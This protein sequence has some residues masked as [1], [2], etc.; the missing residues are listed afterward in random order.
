MTLKLVVTT[1]VDGDVFELILTKSKYR[2]GRRHDNDLRIKETY[3]SAYHSELNRT[4]EGHYELS[5]CGSSNGTY[6]NG[7]K[8]QKPEK[9]KAGDFIKFGILKVAVKEHED[10]GPT[11]VSLK[12]RPVF[13]KKRGENTSSI[14]PSGNTG[15]IGSI[16][17]GATGPSPVQTG[18]T[19]TTSSEIEE[20]EALLASETSRNESL[21]A[22]LAKQE[23]QIQKLQDEV[24][25][26]E[27]TASETLKGASSQKAELEEARKEQD[28]E[29]E[30]LRA[31]LETTAK[32]LQ[33]KL[34][35]EKTRASEIESELEPE[36]GSAK[37]L[38]KKIAVLEAAQ[39]QEQKSAGAAQ[40]QLE[41]ALTTRT[42][43]LTE[44][45]DRVAEL[46][47]ALL[48][49]EEN[50]ANATSE[51]EAQ[52][53]KLAEK[54]KTLEQTIEELTEANSEEAKAREALEETNR[55]QLEEREE[56]V[57][58]LDDLQSELE[59]EKK[60][61]SSVVEELTK[62]TAVAG[63]VALLKSQLGESSN[64]AQELEAE[65][66]EVTARLVAKE[67][68]TADLGSRLKDFEEKSQALEEKNQSLEKEV[69]EK[70]SQVLQQSQ[71]G[72]ELQK[73]LAA[74]EKEK[75]KLNTQLEKKSAEAEQT[76]GELTEL[77]REIKYLQSSVETFEAE[78]SKAST[79]LQEL[80]DQARAL[81][82]EKESLISQR[83]EQNK[84]KKAK[85]TSEEKEARLL[86][87]KLSLSSS[88][89]RLK[90][91]LHG[92]ETE[93]A[94]W[95]EREKTLQHDKGVIARKLEKAEASNSELAAKIKEEQTNAIAHQALVS[96]LET[97][98]SEN[99]S[100][101][102]RREQQRIA[103]VQTELR[104]EKK[105]HESDLQKLEQLEQKLVLLQQKKTEADEQI[106]SL[107]DEKLRLESEQT[108]SSKILQ[109]TE[110]KRATLTSSL[111][112]KT[113]LVATHENTIAE[114]VAAIAALTARYSRSEE[115]LVTEHQQE[116]EKLHN[117]IH[118]ERTAK[119]EL[120]VELE[121]A[122]KRQQQSEQRR[123]KL[124]GTIA[125][126]EKRIAALQK[127]E[128]EIENVVE[129]KRKQG[130]I[131]R[132]EIFSATSA[133]LSSPNG[134][135]SREDF[136]RK[137]INKLDLID[138]LSKRYDNR[139]RYP[140]VAEQLTLLKSSFLDFL[141]DH[142]VKEFNLEP[143]TVLSVEERKRIKLVPQKE[144]VSKKSKPLPSRTNGQRSKVVTT[145][146]PG[147]VYKD[148]G[149]DVIIRKA[150]VIVA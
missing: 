17:S 77:K 104:N 82:E 103:A 122:Q 148:G 29:I 108:S 56:L 93:K 110:K 142:S 116:R 95:T 50:L 86:K 67:N 22:K 23:E 146:R 137:L 52:E 115:K 91:Q 65:K 106:H 8:L 30:K 6:L 62:V 96:K 47:K 145:I 126:S 46:E 102:V 35:Q 149:R 75:S 69:A 14:P 74:A 119:E 32:E 81:S 25:G 24:Q 85:Q 90:D 44:V 51:I 100:E 4:E 113:Q 112:D 40:T 39:T 21:E 83:E 33:E 128:S 136:Y 41:E 7:V 120:A 129:R 79:Q 15:R 105:A 1:N 37:D 11:I 45:S 98:L 64:R 132:S 125:S 72:T 133:E 94:E 16:D 78:Q 80:E 118:E 97:Q 68:E 13:A 42:A 10:K 73:S 92:L 59:E 27:D 99:E 140:R 18:A 134:E 143:G 2:V 123:E 26:Q 54:E 131:S 109:E 117:E 48:E 130:I 89:E 147:Y 135:F 49:K 63:T 53:A 87:E 28:Q 138:D 60:K 141:H 71:G 38:L 31:E 101:S 124:A 61:A 121:T 5:D 150:E 43:E 19:D 12:D 107:R 20:L 3:V 55:S 58:Q 9:I 127:L 70:E 57:Q 34:K 66:E 36:K 76:K 114:K 139:W 144:S 88:F 111:E 84:E